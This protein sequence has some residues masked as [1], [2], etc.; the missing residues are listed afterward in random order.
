MKKTAIILALVCALF[1]LGAGSAS[2]AYLPEYDTT[3]SINTGLELV[4]P[5]DTASLSFQLQEALHNTIT[6]NTGIEIDH[7]YIWIEL[8]GQQ[9]LAIDPA[10]AMY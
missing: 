5:I 2:A 3:I 9:V 4:I 7:Y 10:R 6:E 1:I 8:D